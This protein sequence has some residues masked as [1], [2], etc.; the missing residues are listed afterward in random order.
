MEL[1]NLATGRLLVVLQQ[2]QLVDPTTGLGIA[3]SPGP[4][5]DDKHFYLEGAP[6]GPGDSP[7]TLYALDTAKGANQQARDFIKVYDYSG[8][9]MSFDSSADHSRLFVST[10]KLSQVSLTRHGPSTI[11]SE[12]ALR[13]PSTV[14]YTTP[15][16]AIITVRVIS[17]TTMLLL[18]ENVNGDTSHN[19]LWKMQLDG[20]VLTRLTTTGAG[21][22]SSLNERSLS[23][24]STISRDGSTY[25]LKI[26]SNNGTTQ[27]LLIG[28]LGGTS[29]STFATFSGI[30][31]V[32]IVGWTT[33]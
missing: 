28:S 23:P 24:W 31:S 7:L 15:T 3:V 5:L 16:L 33:M 17:R 25:A 9:W 20:T 29:A 10:F 14:V 22:M 1:L 30:G 4:W 19:G 13:G 27:S 2:T 18:I 8:F 32:A 26:S 21:Q 12:P 11:I 6:N